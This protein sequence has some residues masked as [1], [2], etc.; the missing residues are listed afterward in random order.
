MTLHTSPC[1]ADADVA[2]PDIHTVFDDVSGFEYRSLGTLFREAA[3]GAPDAIALECGD[4]RLS[5]REM[6]VHVA[7]CAAA[8]RQLQLR[9]GDLVGVHLERS[10]R[11][12]ILVM[13]LMISGL[14]YLPLSVDLPP[15]RL[16]LMARIA[17]PALIVSDAGAGLWEGLRQQSS[18]ALFTASAAPEAPALAIPPSAP[19]YVIF[20][21]G[22]TGQPKGVVIHHE[23]FV[24]RLLWA[25]RYYGL[26]AK[27]VIYGRTA[28]SFDPSIQELVLPFISGSRLQVARSVALA[29][30]NHLI[31][32]LEASRATMLIVVP[33]LLRQL[34]QSPAF[35][36]CHAL[37]HVVCCGEPWGPDLITA[38]HRCL[39]GADIYNG[40]GPTE[41][42]IGTLVYRPA[43]GYGADFIP[44]GRPISNVHVALLDES[45]RGVPKGQVGELAIGGVCV[46]QGYVGN[47]AAVREKFRS[48]PVAG[49]GPMRFYLTGDLARELP[50][51]NILFC[52]RKDNQVKIHG[53][54]VELEEIETVLKQLRGV[55]DAIVVKAGHDDGASLQAFIK[56][57][58]DR[59][60]AKALAAHCRSR[61]NPQVVPSLFHRV[62]ALPLLPNGKVD[63]KGV[64][65]LRAAP[66]AEGAP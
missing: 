53:V 37:R 60:D 24:N 61:L 65:Q 63:R 21:S 44:I 46:G 1:P 8:L 25:R 17:Q 49:F 27:D 19:A 10:E 5:Y 16:R 4:L 66:K 51:G 32:S 54:R 20:T 47:E 15:E 36:R 22:S 55:E 41:T 40:Y 58:A 35:A 57:D 30:P 48:L 50:D 34:L 43:R 38:F 52:G 39:P 45:L 7:A 28:L 23:G 13:A 33:S 56:A 59:F 64:A 18:D 42:T 29:L 62:D 2:S 26:D 14:V 31:A 11:Y 3:Q 6:Q 12:V 9:P